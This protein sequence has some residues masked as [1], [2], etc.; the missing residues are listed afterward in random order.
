ML[1]ME[2]EGRGMQAIVDE[3][4]DDEADTGRRAEVAR[5]STRSRDRRPLLHPSARRSTILASVG[6]ISCEEVHLTP[7]TAD[8]P[9]Y[10][11][12]MAG[13]E[14]DSRSETATYGEPHR[15]RDARSQEPRRSASILGSIA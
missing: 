7:S 14:G 2:H 8:G 11:Q 3:H 1:G 13:V 5:S 15:T 10:A 6:G 9:G 4:P 12:P